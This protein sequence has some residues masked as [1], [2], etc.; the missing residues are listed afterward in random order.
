MGYFFF[1]VEVTFIGESLKHPTEFL[2]ELNKYDSVSYLRDQILLKVGCEVKGPIMI[3]E[4]LD[5]H[6]SKFLVCLIFKHI[7]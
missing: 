3:A 1:F 2:I 5:H 4:V 6:L 7:F